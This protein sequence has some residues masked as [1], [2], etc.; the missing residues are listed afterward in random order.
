VAWAGETLIRGGQLA[1]AEALAHELRNQAAI[2][3]EG[4]LLESRIA[5]GQGRIAEIRAALDRAVAECPDDPETLRSR[6]QLLFEQGAPDEA[7]GALRCL[8]AHD[9]ENASAYHNLGTLL[10]RTHHPDEAILAY[11]QALRFRPNHPGTCFHLGCA[12]K[13]DGRLAEAVAAWEQTLRLAPEDRSARDELLN[14]QRILSRG[15][16]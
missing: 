6:C 9:V 2:R 10:L 15:G 14:A 1:A 11:R 8:I 16:V 7:E 12:L 5:L 4:L 13:D 3:V